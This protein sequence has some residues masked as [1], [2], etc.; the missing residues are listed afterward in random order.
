[1]CTVSVKTILAFLLVAAATTASG[2][3]ER[4]IAGRV[5]GVDAETHKIVIET[6][7]GV[8]TISYTDDTRLIGLR[9]DSNVRNVMPGDSVVVLYTE[10]EG[11]RRIQEIK[12]IRLAHR[13]EALEGE[14][15]SVYRFNR[16]MFVEVSDGKEEVCHIA[17]N[18]ILIMNGQLVSMADLAVEQGERVKVYYTMVLGLRSVQAIAVPPV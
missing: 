4:I 2:E 10:K 14:I 16:L 6:E 15:V 13:I 1:M 7:S 9:P 17:D 5:K 12:D 18:A 3:T 11:E 8:E